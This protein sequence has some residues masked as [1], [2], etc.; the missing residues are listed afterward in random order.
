MLGYVCREGQRC[1]HL[2]QQMLLRKNIQSPS[3]KSC[4]IVESYPQSPP[5]K[6]CW[7]CERV[8]H[9]RVISIKTL[10]SSKR[11]TATTSGS[12]TK[13]ALRR[14]LLPRNASIHVMLRGCWALIFDDNGQDRTLIA[15]ECSA[16]SRAM[17]VLP[18]SPLGF[19]IA[20]FNPSL[21]LLHN[22]MPPCGYS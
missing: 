1:V 16:P 17:V 5:Q 14:S 4:S 18:R 15:R 19:I 2:S 3:P 8:P 13:A 21:C 11:T 10:I 12:P 6:T 7:I 9:R 20:S 22:D